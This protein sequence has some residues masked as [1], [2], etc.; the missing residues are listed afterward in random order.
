MRDFEH[1]KKNK[2][3]IDYYDLDEEVKCMMDLLDGPDSEKSLVIIA[4]INPDGDAVGST[5][6]L[7]YYLHEKYEYNIFPF[8]AD[9]LAPGLKKYLSE[10]PVFSALEKPVVEK[11]YAC[12]AVDCAGDYRLAG[13]DLFRDATVNMVIDH[14]VSNSFY[15]QRN[16][17]RVSEAC[18]MNIFLSISHSSWKYYTSRCTN[19]NRTAADYLYLGILHDTGGLDRLNKQ[20]AA[21]VAELIASGAD[22]KEILMK[23]RKNNALHTY[24]AKASLV[25]SVRSAFGNKVAYL[26]VNREQMVNLSLHSETLLEMV[27]ELRD[28]E[29]VRLG[30]I[31][32]ETGNKERE[33][34]FM[35]RS[36]GDWLDLNLFLETFGGGGHFNAAGWTMQLSPGDTIEALVL[37]FLE[38]VKTLKG[39]DESL[40]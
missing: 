33:W 14:H 36:K 24:C 1:I 7:A 16:F 17:V 19:N 5:M 12:I 26:L 39:E 38:R 10:D 27:A 40:L 28:C 4:H 22:H 35:F 20:I 21:A 23:T 3:Q 15:G 25:N 18:C 8:V 37:R 32:Y 2:E 30:F 9:T 13:L 29:D 11:P 6:G 31:G 34:R